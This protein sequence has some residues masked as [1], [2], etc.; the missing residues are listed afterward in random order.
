MYALRDEEG[1]LRALLPDSVVERLAEQ[2]R[3]IW[4]DYPTKEGGTVQALQI[5]TDSKYSRG[6]VTLYLWT[7]DKLIPD[8]ELGG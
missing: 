6:P 2:A 7:G 5:T 3:G 1:T 4:R 8:T